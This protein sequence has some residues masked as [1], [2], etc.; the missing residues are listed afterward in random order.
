VDPQSKREIQKKMRKCTIDIAVALHV[1]EKNSKFGNEKT[2]K[3]NLII[4]T[5]KILIKC[6]GV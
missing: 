2:T 3:M 5:I 4:L 1:L 6:F